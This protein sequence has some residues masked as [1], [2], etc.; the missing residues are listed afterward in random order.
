MDELVN[1]YAKTEDGWKLVFKDIPE[2][3]A[4]GIWR[5]GFKTGENNI[6]IERKKDREFLERQI[7][8]LHRH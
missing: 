3:I 6:S 7:D 4:S 5:A 2:D 8:S 1:V